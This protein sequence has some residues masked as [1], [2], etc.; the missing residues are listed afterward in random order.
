MQHMVIMDKLSGL[1]SEA[2]MFYFIKKGLLK[3]GLY[4][5]DGL[6]SKVTFNAGLTVMCEY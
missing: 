1:Y 3:R 4:L 6:Y 2:T 5:Q